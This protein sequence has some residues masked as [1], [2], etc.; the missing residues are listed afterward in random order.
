MSLKHIV[1]NF[2]YFFVISDEFRK[3]KASQKTLITKINDLEYFST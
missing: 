2:S 1:T 3:S